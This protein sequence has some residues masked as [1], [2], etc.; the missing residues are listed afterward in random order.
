MRHPCFF[1]LIIIATILLLV[2]S[3][4]A[5]P[6]SAPHLNITIHADDSI[7][8]ITIPSG[9]SVLE[10][11]QEAGL[12]TGMLDEVDP[13]P[14]TVLTGE[15][16]VTLTR[17]QEEN[18]IETADLPFSRQYIRSESL[19][20]GEEIL[21]QQGQNGTEEITFL[22]IRVNGEEASRSIL[23]RRT[24]MI[25]QTEI[26]M[27][28][29]QRAYRPI[30]LHG[31]IAY[32]EAGNA[33][34]MQTTSHE[35]TVLVPTGDLDSRVL[36]LSPDGRWLLFSR[37]NPDN[38]DNLINSLWITPT[39][40]FESTPIELGIDNIIHF[41]SWSPV[42]SSGYKIAYS[43]VEP[44][45]S[46]PGWQANND[47]HILSLTRDGRPLQTEFL[48]S[49]NPGGQFGWWGTNFRWS[50][51][52]TSLA[53]YRP[54]A[55][56]LI[57]FQ[58]SDYSILLDF[59]PF[60]TDSGVVWTPQIAWSPD[61]LT[62]F[63]HRPSDTEAELNR[64]P[65]AFDLSA[66][67]TASRTGVILVNNLGRYAYPATTAAS[68]DVGSGA[69]SL[70]LPLDPSQP[71]NSRYSLAILDQDGSNLTSLFPP[72]GAVGLDPNPITF[73]PDNNSILFIR[74]QDLWL[75]DISTREEFQLTSTGQITAFD[76]K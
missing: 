74:G 54:D 5:A 65:P 37:G 6:D 67:N 64:T 52:G 53:F 30:P 27:T 70:L 58:N 40:D 12:T 55:V 63:V 3:G 71:D 26:I 44:R 46:A 8:T 13:P 57:D 42:I 48:I 45:A 38:T 61:N 17:I 76:W 73:S 33:W 28:G 75:L 24:I 43:T 32:V 41:A 14:F 21:L 7:N 62:L 69:I 56:G 31:M 34:L 20:E 35:K 49:E 22:I 19:S 2:S 9:S 1:Q 36:E 66:L 23:S 16:T 39:F 47:L 59:S 15:T 25:P 29:T 50:P 10:A 11:L 72:P 4:C 51:D 68:T 18:W 60:E